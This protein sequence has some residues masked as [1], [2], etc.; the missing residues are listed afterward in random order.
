M[1]YQ[2]YKLIDKIIL[3]CRDI[4]EHEDSQSYWHH[5]KNSYQA[6]L[7]DPS[8]KKQLES[9]RQWAK[10][11]EYGPSYK[12]EEGSWVRDYEIKHDPV[13]FEFDNSGFELELLDCAGGSSQG[14]KLSFWNCIVTKDNTNF[15]IGIN[16]DM[17]LELL[18]NATFINGKCQSPL[19]FITKSGK[20][21][22]TVEGSETWRQCIKDREL[23]N[24][25]KSKAVSKFSFGDMISTATIN[26]IYLGTL[27]QYYTFKTDFEY[28]YR[29]SRDIDYRRCT[30][31]KLAKPIEHH[32]TDDN[33]RN[34]SK[35]SEVLNYYTDVDGAYSPFSYPDVKKKCAKRA[36]TGKLE[37]DCS[38]ENFYKSLVEKIYDYKS[39]QDFCLSSYHYPNDSDR[40]LYSFLCSSLFGF[41][42]ES[43][44][45]D[46][47]LLRR[48]KALGI[49]YVEET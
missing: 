49:Q 48:A 13:E 9:A 28:G 7:V 43:F 45:L 14:G 32:L 6:Y 21:G 5:Y 35:L 22:M 47:E 16:S 23:K 20:V 25:L 1:D 37:L 15:V 31:T 10:W 33:W 26:E 19:L 3:V 4:A 38:E 36:I 17:L 12:N 46:A 27:T 44:E 24:E 40:I 11:T 39:F 18:K 8:N 29:Y 42:T 2:G 30:L 34:F 41:N